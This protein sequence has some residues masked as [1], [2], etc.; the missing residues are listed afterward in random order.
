ML[1]TDIEGSTR[2][3]A[4]LGEGYGDVLREHHRV[5]REAIAACSGAEVDTAGDS[6]FAVFSRAADAVDCAHRAQLALASG[7]WPDGVGPKVRMGIHTGTPEVTDMGFVGIDVHRA[8]RVMAVAYGGQVLLT[9]EAV[10]ALGQ[11]IEV[12]DLGFHRLKDLSEPERLFQLLG[13]GLEADFPRL[14]SLSRSNLPAP[15]DALVG[16]SEAVATA[17][18]LLS[19]PDVRLLTLLGVGGAGKTRLAIEVAGGAVGRYRDGVWLVALAPIQDRALMVSEIARVVEV[20]SVVGQPLEQVLTAA[21]ADRELLLVLDNFEHL[22]D[23]GSMVANL[24]AAAPSVDVLATTREPLRLR[25]EQRMEVQPLSLPAAVELFIQRAWAVR[26][27]LEVDDE[28]RAAIE[29]ICARLDQLPLALELAAAR[30]A[31]FRPRAL[32]ARLAQRLNLPEGPTDLPERQRTLGATIDW[33]YQLLDSGDRVL[34]QSLAAFIGGVRADSAETM[35][36]PDAIDGL[37][38]LAE[39]SLLR[40][41]EDSDLE[42]RF[43]MLETIRE[44]ALQRSAEDGRTDETA[45]RHAEHFLALTEDAAPQLR[46]PEQRRWL[47]RLEDDYPNLRAALDYLTEH[48]SAGAVHMAANLEWFWII[49]GYAIEGRRRLAAA[50]AAAPADS[51]QRGEALV[52]AGQMALQLGEAAEAQL[53]LREAL[54]NAAHEPQ[55]RVMVSALSHLGWAAEALGNHKDSIAHHQHAIAAARDAKDDW[56]L[57]LALNNFAVTLGRSGDWERARPLFQE[58]LLLGRRVGEPRAIALSAHNLSELAF[59]LGELETAYGLAEESLAQARELRFRS[60]IGSAL[61]TRAV[62]SLQRGDLESAGSQLHEAIE[63]SRSA[64]AEDAPA[65]VSVAGMLA[66]MRHEPLLAAQLWAAADQLRDHIG[67]A[68]SPTVESLREKCEAEARA[69]VLNSASWDAA[70]SSGTDAS[71]EQAFALA[72]DATGPPGARALP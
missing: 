50:L 59:E 54:S 16:R 72:L 21:L 3:L 14:R 28:E 38:S 64:Y 35:W 66:A 1:F 46:G 48:S 41:R 25:G 7:K 65:L 33:S 57:G 34:L 24:I 44:F 43:W 52:A 40:C 37:A 27:T 20:D 67:L 8:A 56:A 6:F 9:Q 70:W 53:L 29:R 32:E 62:I 71:V 45:Q 30:V 61:C 11:S 22:L 68:E 51:P 47:D 15:A 26:P 49:R 2:M 63:L 36:R 23:A 39:K 12:H 5:M 18:E 10:H 4:R 55:S 58:S 19:R 42:P 31:V 17:L 13:P 60:L 69:A